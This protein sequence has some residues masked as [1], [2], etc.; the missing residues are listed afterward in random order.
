M[1][2]YQEPLRQRERFLGLFFFLIYLDIGLSLFV[3]LFGVCLPRVLHN[4]PNAFNL[5]AYIFTEEM[6]AQ[7]DMHDVS[8]CFGGKSR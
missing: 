3:L 2:V 1:I 7:E 6:A 5:S 8:N 4:I